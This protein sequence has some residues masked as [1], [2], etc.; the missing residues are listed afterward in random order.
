MAT[1]KKH[2]EPDLKREPP[3]AAPPRS[4]QKVT[5]ACK[6]PSGLRLRLYKMEE[7][8]EPILGGGTRTAKRAVQVGAEV[9]LHGT[10]TRHGQVPD[11]LIVG[12]YALTQNVDKDFFDEWLRLNGDL[13]AV[14]NNLVFAMATE[15]EARA[16]ATE[17]SKILSGLQPLDMSEIVRDGRKVA[18]DRRLPRPAPGIPDG[19]A[20]A[21]KVA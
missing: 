2:I 19:V 5:V 10:A 17:Q 18:A 16:R 8:S 6:L 3:V 21:E 12:G 20:T 7:Y 15:G 1:T 11:F 14:R 9:L 13:D 4:G